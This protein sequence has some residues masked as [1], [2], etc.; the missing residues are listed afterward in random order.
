[1]KILI[2]NDDGIRATG[3]NALRESLQDQH[4]VYVVAPDRERSA[5]GHKITLDR[6][7]RVK[8]WTYPGSSA[9]GWEVDGTP[10]DCVKLGLEALLPEPPDL[11]VS[12]INFG[13]NL[14]TDVLYSGTVSAAVEGMIN[15][16]P[17]IA[18]SLA[19]FEFS[20][21]SFSSKIIKEVVSV[22]EG[23]LSPRT[24]LN[25][26]TPPCAPRGIKV[27][28]LGDRRYVNIFDKRIDPRGRVYFWMGGE[29]FDLDKDDPETDVWAIRE[30][31]I[32]MTPIQFDLTDYNFMNRLEN[33]CKKIGGQAP[34][35]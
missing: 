23:E 29:P 13:P 16:I 3:L 35:L 5:T 18:I 7:L 2:S 8:E 14:G 21:F 15:D 26:N 31:Y 30:G 25:I 9:I 4:Q 24:L 28:R 20:D 19:S 33:I 12:G 27:T 32:S 34:D 11:V 17:S 1:M 22:I 6:P 10:A